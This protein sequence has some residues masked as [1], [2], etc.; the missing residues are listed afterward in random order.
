MIHLVQTLFLC[1]KI[2]LLAL[3][4]GKLTCDRRTGGVDKGLRRV[5]DGPDAKAS[6]LRLSNQLLLTRSKPRPWEGHSD[7]L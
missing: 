6:V 7:C 1:G 3:G 2:E 4:I 5:V